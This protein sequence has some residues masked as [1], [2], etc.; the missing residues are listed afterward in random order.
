MDFHIYRNAAITLQKFVRSKKTKLK[1]KEMYGHLSI[2]SKAKDS[3]ST[4]VQ[5]I[6]Q[7]STSGID[8][9][10]AASEL[11]RIWRGYNTRL[12]F[13]LLLAATKKIQGFYRTKRSSL[14]KTEH[15]AEYNPSV[16]SEKI[17]SI[18]SLALQEDKMSSESNTTTDFK[19][20]KNECFGIEGSTC[21]FPNLNLHLSGGVFQSGVS[22]NN[23]EVF[24]FDPL[25]DKSSTSI[26]MRSREDVHVDGFEQQPPH[27]P[28]WKRMLMY[29]VKVKC[30]SHRYATKEKGLT[31]LKKVLSMRQVMD[32]KT[33]LLGITRNTCRTTFFH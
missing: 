13:L 17:T 28:L 26:Y 29:R 22:H 27:R 2:S 12:D 9:N 20:A 6:C 21:A 30:S 8:I 32:P 1:Q 33:T 10:F 7:E 15:H 4:H 18:S 25:V 3:E 19:I 5:S 23:E 16:K 24:S 11:Q 14:M 31:N